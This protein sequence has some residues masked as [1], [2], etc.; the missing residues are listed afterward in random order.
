MQITS[1]DDLLVCFLFIEISSITSNS[2]FVSVACYCTDGIMGNLYFQTWL[3]ESWYCSLF[4]Y[5]DLPL[6]LCWLL[7]CCLLVLLVDVLV[8][9]WG[10]WCCVVLGLWWGSAV[11]ISGVCVSLCRLVSC[12]TSTHSSLNVA[13]S[14]STLSVWSPG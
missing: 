13:C 14:A 10:L 2:D 6:W 7:S 9:Q 8:V 5:A 12:L 11:L 4:C 1:T 3:L